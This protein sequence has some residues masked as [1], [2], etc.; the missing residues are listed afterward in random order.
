MNF[1]KNVRPWVSFW[2][3]MDI[4]CMRNDVFIIFK[5]VQLISW[6]LRLLH[7]L[8]VFITINPIYVNIIQ[9]IFIHCITCLSYIAYMHY[10]FILYS[11][12]ESRD[13]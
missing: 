10:V 5:Y 4:Q 3:A 12:Y 13:H 6:S 2:P 1:I 7:W 9:L 8:Y 11:I